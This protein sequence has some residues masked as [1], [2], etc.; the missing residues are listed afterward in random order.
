MINLGNMIVNNYLIPLSKG[1]MLVDTGYESGYQRFCGELHKN[2]VSL[3]EI[4]YIFVTHAHDD[5]AGFVL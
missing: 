2:N 5:H 3:G 4:R 1:Y